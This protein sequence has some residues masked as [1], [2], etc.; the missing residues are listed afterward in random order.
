MVQELSE[1]LEDYLEAIFHLQKEF[2]VARVKDIASRLNV[3]MPSVTN[4]LKVLK[5]KDLIDYEKN[6]FITLTEKGETVAKKIT[7]KHAVCEEFFS[8]MLNT[9]GGEACDLACAVEHHLS[10]KTA[11]K[12]EALTVLI[13]EWSE[14]DSSFLSRMTDI[15]NS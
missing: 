14:N 9:A 11:A 2:K 6:S 7:H 15:R 1:S 5:A 4:A 13:R 10:G 3:K 8:E 12:I